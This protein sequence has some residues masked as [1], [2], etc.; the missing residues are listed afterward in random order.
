M[1]EENKP[2]APKVEATKPAE[3]VK[4][5]AP[6]GTV[7]TSMQASV[8]TPPHPSSDLPDKSG[9]TKEVSEARARAEEELE[10]DGPVVA[11]NRGK[12]IGDPIQCIVKKRFFDERQ[13]LIR[14]GST[15]YFQRREGETF[16]YKVLEPVSKAVAAS[17]RKE[18]EKA[19]A[20]KAETA[21][22]RKR[23]REAFARMAAETE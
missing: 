3:N 14:E 5:V 6:A 21:S 15:Y 19:Q 4:V 13:A 7:P 18:Y 2:G 17:V 20:D 1:P 12:S 16:P 9:D 23:R 11:S 8:P 22:E 10:E